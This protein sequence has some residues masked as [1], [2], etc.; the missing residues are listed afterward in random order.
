MNNNEILAIFKKQMPDY[1]VLTI[2][3]VNGK[4]V[5]NA[6][7][8]NNDEECYD[9]QYVIKGGK[10][11][12]YSPIPEMKAFQKALENPV[13]VK[14][15]LKHYGIKGMHWGIRRFQ[16]E[17]GTLTSRG[18]DRYYE[19]STL[20][21]S[22]SK[23][24]AVTQVH[25]TANDADYSSKFNL[26]Q[27][28]VYRSSELAHINTGYYTG[29]YY[30][31][32]NCPRTSLAC[33]LYKR[34]Y[35]HFIGNKGTGLTESQIMEM[36]TGEES[37]HFSNWTTADTYNLRSRRV[38]GQDW[39][40]KV[41]EYTGPPGSHGVISGLYKPPGAAGGHIF[42]YTVLEDGTI[43]IE[44][45]QPGL[46]MT[47]EAAAQIYDFGNTTVT[48]LTNASINLSAMYD[49]NAMNTSDPKMNTVVKKVNTYL[50]LAKIVASSPAAA[51]KGARLA[52]QI[53]SL[54]R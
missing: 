52:N 1:E 26:P 7:N 20:G 47:L 40:D 54:L 9:I 51:S 36:Y 11:I 44:D 30:S 42:N 18:R 15:E 31:R 13:Y 6:V 53:L 28:S 5:I 14:N 35:S 22:N 46:I 17:D 45:A 10:I 2:L 3:D 38:N 4:A 25:R 49:Y 33:E 32:N 19:D 39:C 43:Q 29:D 48:N 16:N 37:H 12:P 23:D 27:G 8:R 50:S 41:S 21:S 24:Y 34:G